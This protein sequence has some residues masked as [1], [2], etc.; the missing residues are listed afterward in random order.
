MDRL[1]NVNAIEHARYLQGVYR[2]MLPFIGAYDHVI[3]VC[4]SDPQGSGGR[5]DRGYFIGQLRPD[6]RLDV[7]DKNPSRGNLTMDLV[8]DDLP[9]CD[10]AITTGL[11]HH[12]EQIW[13]SRLMTA[14]SLNT[15]NF[16]IICG[17]ADDRIDLFGDHLSNIDFKLLESIAGSNGFE[18]EHLERVGLSQPY[19]EI[20]LVFRREDGDEAE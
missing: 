2:K 1:R 10:V 4:G 7:V 16:V 3:E 18:L 6:A 19:C 9:H 11:F 17:P 5:L 20:L 14:M 15:R 12:H 13:A 8:F